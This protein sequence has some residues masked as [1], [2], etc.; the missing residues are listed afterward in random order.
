MPPVQR[1]PL[2]RFSDLNLDPG[3]QAGG[4][5]SSAGRSLMS[6][7]LRL[8]PVL[9]PAVQREQSG[10]E[11]HVDIQ[12]AAAQGVRGAGQPLPHL[13][14]IQQAFGKHDLHAVVAHQGAEAHAASQQIGAAAYTTGHHVAFSH[15]PDLHTAAHEAAHVVQQRA[16]VQLKGGVGQADDPY[17]RHA[18]AVADR[19]VRGES[20]E[21]VLDRHP[22][23]G[24]QQ[25][26]QL[27]TVTAEQLRKELSLKASLLDST[28]SQI[29]KSVDKYE[30]TEQI[31]DGADERLK[32]GVEILELIYKWKS[33]QRTNDSKNRRKSTLLEVLD[34]ELREDVGE[35]LR[36][37][38]LP[39]D[40]HPYL[41]RSRYFRDQF[42]STDH[43][44][45]QERLIK[46]CFGTEFAAED[47]SVFARGP[48]W[49]KNSMGIAWDTLE[50]LPHEYAFHNKRMKRFL[51]QRTN[52]RPSS[53]EGA[54]NNVTLVAYADFSNNFEVTGPQAADGGNAQR[55]LSHVILHEYGHSI[56]DK[57]KYS[58]NPDLNARTQWRIYKN[59]KELA[60]DILNSLGI[61][62]DRLADKLGA[63][64]KKNNHSSWREALT[65]FCQDPIAQRYSDSLQQLER[66]KRQYAGACPWFNWSPEQNLNDRGRVFEQPYDNQ[67][68]VSYKADSHN[69]KVSEYQFRS[70]EEWFAEAF[71]YYYRQAPATG[72]GRPPA[73]DLRRCDSGTAAWFDANMPREDDATPPAWESGG[74]SNPTLPPGETEADF[75]L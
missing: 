47:R 10:A 45:E 65:S 11:D 39:E 21:D 75:E 30:H 53:V 69:Y 66:L 6:A 29:V 62:N 23:P 48:R 67:E 74:T 24:G 54:Y 25:G 70:P 46:E 51:R 63:I 13:P 20:A 57:K 14:R 43:I 17:E 61:E 55:K 44:D 64:I 32:W 41:I 22:G 2:H 68:W 34:A 49:S 60:I 36:Q 71:A 73:A 40:S 35:A 31:Q 7:P 33:R 58:L 42:N 1:A 12:A 52:Q 72:T 28:W 26:V 50:R 19:V 4:G 9:S 5:T 37:W 38:G 56:D 3:P 15:P 8:D 18:D 27:L 59:Y 16:G